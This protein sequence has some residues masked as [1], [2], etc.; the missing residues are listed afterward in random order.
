MN[1]EVN[2]TM[3]EPMETSLPASPVNTQSFNKVTSDDCDISKN[4]Q[5]NVDS[6]ETINHVDNELMKEESEDMSVGGSG[7]D[8]DDADSD[9][10]DPASTSQNS[11]TVPKQETSNNITDDPVENN[12][13][14]SNE[15]YQESM[16]SSHAKTENIDQ[17]VNPCAEENSK[18]RETENNC[19]RTVIVETDD[20]VD[21]EEDSSEEGSVLSVE[22]RTEEPVSIDSDS[23]LD[24][25][26]DTSQES[27]NKDKSNDIIILE[28][29]NR[30]D[31]QNGNSLDSQSPEVHE[32]I[33]D[34]ENDDCVLTNDEK[35]SSSVSDSKV[36]LRRSSRA[37]K[38]KIYI[39]E[40]M[41]NGGNGSDIEEVEMEDPLNRKSKPI[42]INDTKA[43]VAMA[44]KQ[45]KLGVSPQNQKKEPT[46][47]II[48]TN[49]IISGKT[50]MP[51]PAKTPVT[52]MSAENLYQSIVARGTTVT[53]VSSKTNTCNSTV[54][55]NATQ[56][57]QTSILPSLTDDMFVVEAPSFIVPYVY[58]KPSVKPFR[59]FVD[60]LGKE[61]EEQRAKEEQDR[62]EKEKLEKE[63]LD[64]ERKEKKERGEEVEA[65][66]EE[67][68]KADKDSPT[69]R[70]RKND[71]DDASWDGESSVDSEDEINSDEEDKTVVIKDKADS[72]EEIKDVSDLIS[73]KVT[74]GKSDNY[75]DCSLGKFFINIGLNFVQ[76][77]V[78]NDLLKQQN[79]K[80]YREKKAGHSTKATESSIS[81]LM[82]NLEFSKENNA[83]Y[84]YPQIKCEF[85]SFKTESM[86]VM[87]HH[88]ETPHMKNNV[89]KC[90]FCA[91]EIRS[92]HDI[93]YHMEAEHNT[94]GK[95]ERAPA[96]H[97]CA[98]CPFEDN[99]KGKLARHLIP[100]AK[101]FKPEGGFGRTQVGNN[102]VRPPMNM[103]S[104]MS[105]VG[106][107][108]GS[109]RARGRTPAAAPPRAPMIRGVMVRHTTPAQNNNKN[110][111]LPKSMHQPS[112]SITPLPRQP[113]P[114]PAPS[115]HAKSTFV[116]CEIC[117][118]YI[119]DL[120]QLRNHMQWIH[121]VKIHPK[122]IYNR[123]PLNCQKCQF[124]FF[125]DQGLERHLLGTHGLVTS[126]MQEAANKGKD[127]GRCPVCGRVYQ[128]KL[129]NHVA[130]DHNLTLKPAHLSYKCTVC[131]ATFGMYKQ[132]ENH[133]YSAHSVVAKRVMDKSKA[134]PAPKN[135]SL[136]KPLKI[137][138]EIT[139]IPQP[140]GVFLGKPAV[141]IEHLPL[142]R[143]KVDH[144]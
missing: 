136:L 51:V 91:F 81:S 102:I 127:A 101:K 36:K 41:E 25:A 16:T 2:G 12:C 55:Q 78:Q 139:I 94:R 96:Y 134:A 110:A 84:R 97:Q 62:L 112:I 9:P 43:L 126:S 115:H 48:D 140:G 143:S 52:T 40:E 73:D 22:P 76:E 79:R 132:F 99:G 46:V 61:L 53:P 63:K 75:F 42:V 100:C 123:P 105:G 1:G 24:G 71:D 80:L 121:K 66:E 141:Y 113:Q 90:N 86:L 6:S 39:D 17:D 92:P 89:Y 124:R 35:S 19:S 44:V 32:I 29:D 31:D 58:E 14:N 20:E 108:A 47:V 34:N 59:E 137:N 54:T 11:N 57:A 85:C 128:W 107:G 120:E 56:T 98:N 74:S 13:I 133:V 26:D 83:P 33:S 5:E 49:S 21:S 15:S 103:A 87:A 30:P 37:I 18:D 64:K 106:M 144:F 93:L 114:P 117:D 142:P 82:K 77:Y 68:E 135:D 130:R 125:T 50:V 122:M 38:R 95:L 129:L 111:V 4:K 45:A 23:E 131:T 119:K 28:N 72:I 3:E 7:Q 118:G 67:T 8:D 88:L 104:L 138:D 60:I 27:Q 109:F 65:S 116:I 69:R 10:H 70:M